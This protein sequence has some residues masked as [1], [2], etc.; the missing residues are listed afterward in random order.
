MSTAI[1]T[2]PAAAERWAGWEAPTKSQR[3]SHS[4]LPMRR[5][6]SLAWSFLLMVG[7][8]RSNLQGPIAVVLD[9]TD[10]QK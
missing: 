8:L 1:E 2:S 4:S 10:R 5:A 7:S 3:L 9:S 6:M